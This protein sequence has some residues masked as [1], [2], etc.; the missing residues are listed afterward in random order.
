MHTGW[1]MGD[2]DIDPP[3]AN[4]IHFFKLYFRGSLD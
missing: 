4:K 3:Q 1:K 2:K